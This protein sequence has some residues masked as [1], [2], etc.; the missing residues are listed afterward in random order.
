MKHS[1]IQ[2]SAIP[3]NSLDDSHQNHSKDKEGNK[4]N[5]KTEVESLNNNQSTSNVVLLDEY[6][7]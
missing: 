2:G 4:E 7:H 1:E 3:K 6:E 5:Q